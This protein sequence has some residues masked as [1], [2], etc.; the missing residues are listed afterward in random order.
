MKHI[1]LNGNLILKVDSIVSVYLDAKNKKGE[2][3]VIVELDNGVKWEFK[4][5]L[6]DVR[7]E[8]MALVKT[9]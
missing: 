5:Y 8:L 9:L 1:I 2:E 7:E 3:C 4:N 6:D